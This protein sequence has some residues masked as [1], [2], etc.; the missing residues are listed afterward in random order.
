[1]Q[2]RPRSLLSGPPRPPPAIDP[3]ARPQ[4]FPGRTEFP[5]L[6]VGRLSVGKSGDGPDLPAEAEVK[7][8]NRAVSPKL[9][10]ASW[11]IIVVDDVRVN[12]AKLRPDPQVD[13]P[14][15]WLY[16]GIIDVTN[17]VVV[18]IDDLL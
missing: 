16:D 9:E 12:R 6:R 15:I 18:P 1:M 11:I 2:D 3:P 5:R 7:G 4:R 13:H 17:A 8:T 14:E 10:V